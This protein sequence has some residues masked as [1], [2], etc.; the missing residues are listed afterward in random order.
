MGFRRLRAAEVCDAFEKGLAEF[1]LSQKP[2]KS[3]IHFLTGFAG[4][5]ILLSRKCARQGAR[6]G[7]FPLNLEA[8][9]AAF[10]FCSQKTER[11]RV[12]L[13]AVYLGREKKEREKKEVC[14]LSC[15]DYSIAQGG[16][17]KVDNLLTLSEQ[18]MNVK[19]GICNLLTL[20][21]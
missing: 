11:K 3:G 7:C 4:Q 20:R 12:R 1:R 9:S 5:K 10:K 15:Y 17:G 2:E 8:A 6:G 16:G 19:T 18:I 21:R 13:F 14:W